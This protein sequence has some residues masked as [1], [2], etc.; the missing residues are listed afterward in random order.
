MAHMVDCHHL[1]LINIAERVWSYRVGGSRP[2]AVTT[3]SGGAGWSACNDD[4]TKRQT[5][6]GVE[7]NNRGAVTVW[8][9]CPAPWQLA[10]SHNHSSYTVIR[11]SPEERDRLQRLLYKSPRTPCCIDELWPP[12][13]SWHNDACHQSKERSQGL[14]KTFQPGLAPWTMDVANFNRRLQSEYLMLRILG[15]GYYRIIALWMH[16]WNKTL[17]FICDKNRYPN[18]YSVSFSKL[19]VLFFAQLHIFAFFFLK[20]HAE[21]FNTF[22]M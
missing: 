18:V 5:L 7:G 10:K 17:T 13:P 14:L 1:A 19:F 12:Y 16:A 2:P 20:H 21:I 22:E 3:I 6:P 8:L 11:F 4:V 9:R 15:E